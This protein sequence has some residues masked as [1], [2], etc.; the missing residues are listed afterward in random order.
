MKE[1]K[2]LSS[3]GPQI[4]V[5]VNVENIVKYLS[6]ASVAI[7]SIIFGTRCLEKLLS[8]KEDNLYK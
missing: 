8:R 6:I 2:R 4:V 3:P 1:K 7:I 5:E